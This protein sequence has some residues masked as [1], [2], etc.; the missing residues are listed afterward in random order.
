MSENAIRDQNYVPSGLAVLNTDSVQG[1]NKVR[2][3]YV[4][5]TNGMKVTTSDT[6]SF[7][8][9]PI[10]AQDSNY[11]DCLTFEGTDGLVYP[12]VAN[13]AGAVLVDF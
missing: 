6:I 5:L 4:E 2:I 12:W 10:D 1:T 8:M 9:V 3:K 7:T 11:V 13:S